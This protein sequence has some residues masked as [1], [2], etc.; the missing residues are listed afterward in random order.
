[1]SALKTY[2]D[3]VAY[4]LPLYDEDGELDY[5]AHCH[6]TQLARGRDF[7]HMLGLTGISDYAESLIRTSF[8]EL[9]DVAG[10]AAALRKALVDLGSAVDQS[11]PEGPASETRMQTS[12]ET[13]CTVTSK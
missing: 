13:V 7:A 9:E 1:M 4:D 2:L 6:R 11:D 8:P 5:E 10:I 3:E 12:I